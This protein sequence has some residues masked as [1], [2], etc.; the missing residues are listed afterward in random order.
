MTCLGDGGAEGRLDKTLVERGDYKTRARAADAIKRGCVTVNGIVALKPGQSISQDDRIVIDDP[1]SGYVSRG[2][3]KLLAAL[4]HFGFSP[5]GRL[6]LDVGASTGGF[7]Q[8]LL[9]C[10]A[11]KVCALDV[12][13]DQLAGEIAANPKVIRRDGL[14]ARFLTQAD[15]PFSPDAIVVDVS[16]VSLRLVLP[17]V[18]ALASPCAWLVTLVKPQFEVGRE[19]LGKGG[20]VNNAEKARASAEALSAW[21]DNQ[22]QWQSAGLSASPIKGSDGNT[23]FLLG[24]LKSA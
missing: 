6:C 10:G 3:L 11:A 4:D 19:A 20:I 24:G 9:E 23:E 5:E 1:A 18:L 7:T 16:F 15:V 21:L 17:S 22:N 2:A 8:V 13:H 14:K 12:G